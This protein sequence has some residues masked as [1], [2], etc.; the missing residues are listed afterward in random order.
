MTVFPP[1]DPKKSIAQNEEEILKFWKDNQIFEKSIE[2]R[3]PKR[4]YVFYDGPPFATGMPHYGHFLAST[5]KDVVPRYWTMKG[6]RVERRFGWDCHGLPIENIV[7]KELGSKS[8]KDIEEKIGIEKFNETCRSK[9][10]MYVDEWEKVVE[11]LGRWVD[12]KNDYKTMDLDFMESVM[13]LFAELHKKKLIYEGQRIS[14][15]CPRCSTPLSNFEIA[16]DN[17]YKIRHDQTA[18]VKFRLLSRK[19]DDEVELSELKNDEE[20]ESY[21]ALR[22]QELERL[23][24]DIKYDPNHP[25]EKKKNHFPRG[26]FFKGKLI[27]T[28]R[29]DLLNETDVAF[30][31]I[32]ISEKERGSGFGS[33]LLKLAED[34]AQSKG[35]KNVEI[36]TE[37]DEKVKNFYQKNGYEESVGSEGEPVFKKNISELK[38][39]DSTFIL[40]WT[41]TPW[42]LPSNFALCVNPELNY[43]K[44]K[45]ENE[46]LIV[47][48][49]L[50]E[51]F[52]GKN[53]KDVSNDSHEVNPGHYFITFNTE[54][55]EA[56]FDTEEK[57]RTCA[58]VFQKIV[59]TENY[60]V[61]GLAVM[62]DHVHL[63]I[64]V[65]E[66]GPSLEKMLQKLKGVSSRFLSQHDIFYNDGTSNFAYGTA[67]LTQQL[68]AGLTPSEET[69]TQVSEYNKIWRRGY[70]KKFIYDDTEYERI[71]EYILQ[72][73]EKEGLSPQKYDWLTKIDDGYVAPEAII[74]EKFPGKDLVG[75]E[76]EP[77]FPYFSEK[78]KEGLFR[79]VGADFVSDA[80]GTG[81]VHLAPFGEDDFNYATKNKLPIQDMD[82]VDDHSIFKKEIMHF[83]GMSV[84]DPE[85]NKK[86]NQFLESEGTLF[87]KEQHSHSYPHCYRCETPLIYKPQ[88]AY[89]L[90]VQQIK[91]KMLENNK[92]INWVPE[93]LKEGRFQHGLEGAPDW[94]LSR[95]RYWGSPIPIWKCNQCEHEQTVGSIT[96]LEKLSGE[97]VE[98]LHKHFVDKLTWKC[99][100]CAG[101]MHRTP[102]VLDCWFESGAMPYAQKHYPFAN[103][104]G[105]MQNAEFEY[106]EAK[107]KE[108]IERCMELRKEIFTNE[109]GIDNKL[110]FDG[111]DFET[112][113]K[114]FF[115]QKDGKI[116]GT[117][118]AR[119]V[120]KNI[121]K[122]ERMA[123]LKSERGKNIGKSIIE[124]SKKIAIK[125]RIKKYKTH[126]QI[127][128][129]KFWG[130][131]GFISVGE[132]F[133][134]AG[135]DHIKMELDILNSEFPLPN[136]DF[137]P[138]DFIAEY[139]AQTRGW[140]YTLH[141]LSTALMDSHSFKNCICTGTILAEDGT[142]M[143][144]SKKNFPD[145]TLIFDKYGS[146]AMRFY[147][148]ASS[149]MKGE[150][151]NFA[152]AGVEEVLK[153]VILP[154]R[155]AYNF[156]ST[157]ANID[158]WQPTKFT[159]VRHGEGTQNV[160]GIYSG[161]TVQTAHHLTE[162]GKKEVKATAKNLPDFDVLFA[163]PFERTK[164]TA[165]I[166]KAEKNFSGEAIFDDRLAEPEFGELDGKPLTPRAE[167][168]KLDSP[169]KP[170][171]FVPRVADFFSEMSKAHQGKNI[172]VVTHGDIIRSF[173][174]VTSGAK[175]NVDNF[176]IFPKAD[177]GSH[178]IA[179][180]FPDPKNDLDKWILSELQ[181]TIKTFRE[182]FDK[183]ELETA[184]RT[185]PKFVDNLNNWYLRRSRRRFWEGESGK[186]SGDKQS[187]YKTLHFALLNL[188]KLLAPVCPFFA[189]K[190][191]QDLG[192]GESVHLESF[193]FPIE[194][195]VDKQSESQVEVSREIVKL[196]AAIRARKKIKLR[197]PLGKLR[198]A[199][200]G[201]IGKC[202]LPLE[203]IAEEANV[204]EVEILKSLKGIAQKIVKVDARQV[205]KKFGGKVQELIV[206]GKK[207][208]FK[209]LKDGQIEVAGE[210]LESGEYE[211][212][213]LC[214][215]GVE[216]EAT[217]R[218]V[219]L[220]DTEIS[221][222]LETEGFA[223]EIIRTIQ[224]MRKTKGFEVSD[225]I[226]VQYETDSEVL[227]SAF[228][229]FEAMIADET[230]AVEISQGTGIGEE[231][232]ELDGEKV[233]ITLGK[234]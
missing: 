154:I 216:A 49:N 99:K 158:G 135:I 225:R 161:Y 61:F 188:S 94:N 10:M 95:N 183:Y 198:F 195:W 63:T 75:Q 83:S 24:P 220:L 163:S 34:F 177:T 90:D 92:E 112:G 136:S 88:R 205:G 155:N 124:F 12:F 89:F 18:T 62:P 74:V 152:E 93:H 43:V 202:R 22:K 197:Q 27:G 190:L 143:S 46:I 30:R 114:H 180:A 47:T 21:H 182:S 68:T 85:T 71:H 191:F 131:C 121:W 33:K 132:I 212:G 157:Y 179:F 50:V 69:K 166:L 72:N 153:T 37:K 16:M 165:A 170:E 98:D 1:I 104:E 125:N 41:T 25:D 113:T 208:N 133:Q 128:V 194:D 178:F 97:K 13:W 189:D 105:G 70:D 111:A 100:K 126:A 222:E 66:S 31:M 219:V 60:R 221:A 80:D 29:I 2:T 224:E 149:V 23:Y 171:D 115:A 174:L 201:D 119:K 96:E 51:K 103:A 14:L 11:R 36:H 106:K 42:T 230:L 7:E 173:H 73:P 192:G 8:K 167:R 215:E 204:K 55:G 58:E 127:S 123:V 150:N 129:Q 35:G 209:E 91:D 40:A 110:D 15:Y 4:E 229:Q 107:T 67:P 65:E 184:L 26:L 76:Y 226:T 206:E 116:C 44:V 48:E 213:F 228:D 176:M 159:F 144:K 193:P 172:C 56:I 175:I 200:A 86:I 233:K 54:G 162:K 57:R 181:T 64:E 28:V 142:K 217:Q 207:G 168:Y 77:L 141:V 185:I 79:V 231:E 160:E 120:E 109:Q 59:E 122:V 146:D 19:A 151:F 232:I 140:F 214:E 138:A 234:K 137:Q 32:T 169:D 147:L 117:F 187:A 164:E 81:I 108:M 6:Y 78:S 148:M 145:P 134:E 102:E 203:V 87:K 186:I 199:L 118:R 223:R 53:V 210:V 20:L 211:F 156:F 84:I 45:H 52:F 82:A 218:T 3:S 101:K 38:N 130:K 9:V 39:A 5:I 227:K 196:A 17:S 139:I